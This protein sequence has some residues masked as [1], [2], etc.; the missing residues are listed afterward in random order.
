AFEA[1]LTSVEPEVAAA[2][3][4]C[5]RKGLRRAAK[6]GVFELVTVI[7]PKAIHQLLLQEAKDRLSVQLGRTMAMD[8]SPDDLDMGVDPS[9]LVH[10]YA[11]SGWLAQIEAL[12]NALARAIRLYSLVLL[13]L[14]RPGTTADS[15]PP[16]TEGQPSPQMPSQ[17][18]TPEHHEFQALLVFTLEVLSP[19]VTLAQDA[20]G[21]SGSVVN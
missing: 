4:E 11:G 18:P 19:L 16:T 12:P 17:I 8:D 2:W 9:K 1:L 21:A 3:L 14:P 5:F 20:Q 7:A 13:G 15:H 10:S 6:A